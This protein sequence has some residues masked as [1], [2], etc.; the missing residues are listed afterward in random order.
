MSHAVTDANAADCDGR[1]QPTG[2][3]RA[4]PD[5][6]PSKVP[7]V[8]VVMPVYNSERYVAQAVESILAQTFTD[9]EFLIVEDGSTDA[10]RTI[11]E[12]YAARDARIRLASRPNR[13]RLVVAL[14]EML[15]RARGDLIARMDADDV[16]LPERFERQVAYLYEHPACV[17]VG[18]RVLIIDPDG[19]EITVMGNALSHKEIVDGFLANQ[20]QMMYH[21]AVMFRREAV[22]ALGGYD[23]KMIEAEDLHL[24]L[25]LADVGEIVN[26]PEPLLKYREHLKKS[27]RVRAERLEQYCQMITN[28]ARKQRNMGPLPEAEP[29][30]PNAKALVATPVQIY[31]TWAWW[32]LQSGRLRTSR[33]YA[34][35][36]LVRKPLSRSSWK[37]LLC[38]LRGY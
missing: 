27:G 3:P 21:P 8:S 20:G 22:M 33:K 29:G 4:A 14:N 32:A 24:F 11:L 10:S 37:L 35:A 6:G 34:W 23:V 16:A 9:F 17:L 18:S 31:Q 5:A 15:G 36:G 26:L 2:E 7:S 25:R 13:G 1:E 30:P 38:A 12:S 28:E 19:D